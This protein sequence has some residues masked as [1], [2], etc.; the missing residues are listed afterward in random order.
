MVTSARLSPGSISYLSTQTLTPSARSCSA[1]GST[2]RS[3]SS[4]AWLRKA[5]GCLYGQRLGTHCLVVTEAAEAGLRSPALI[6]LPPVYEIRAL[7]PEQATLVR[8]QH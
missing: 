5:L 6:Y 7:K 3:L 8:S 2:N 4:L 1:N